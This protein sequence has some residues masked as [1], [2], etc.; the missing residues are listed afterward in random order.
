MTT[1]FTLFLLSQVEER[2]VARNYGFIVSTFDERQYVLSAVTHGIRNNWINALKS[3]SNLSNT[4]ESDNPKLTR[5]ETFDGEIRIT[6]RN[7]ADSIRSL[8]PKLQSPILKSPTEEKIRLEPSVP[9]SPPLTRTPTS[10]IKKEKCKSNRVSSLKSTQS[11]SALPLQNGE[12]E[13]R[14]KDHDEDFNMIP[15]RD[16]SNNKPKDSPHNGQVGPDNAIMNVLETEVTSL[17]SQLEH[18]QS[19]LLQLHN[20]SGDVTGQLTK[21]TSNAYNEIDADITMSENTVLKVKMSLHDAKDMLHKQTNE[22][23]ILRTKMDNMNSD[24]DTTL[25]NLNNEHTVRIIHDT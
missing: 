23:G 2:D 18:S 5:R 19:E 24:M 12:P 25:K 8:S 21:N 7:T 11:L 6:R 4:P 17:K 14:P 9:I 1:N 10:R 22:I 3:A 16:T 13:I 20:T 15:E